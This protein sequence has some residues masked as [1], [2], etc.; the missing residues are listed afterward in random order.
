MALCPPTPLGDC[1]TRGVL[2][3][4]DSGRLADA[5]AVLLADH[6]ADCHTCAAVLRGRLHQ[7]HEQDLA[8][9]LRRC[10]Q[11]EFA[12]HSPACAA[13]EAAAKGLVP[14]ALTETT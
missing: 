1:P 13:M 10:W 5:D 3:D 4:F 7:S 8:D 12:L 6:V 14:A 2:I 9:R 11:P